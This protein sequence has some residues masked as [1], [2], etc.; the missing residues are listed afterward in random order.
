MNDIHSEIGRTQVTATSSARGGEGVGGAEKSLW[1][2]A[3]HNQPYRLDLCLSII[4]RVTLHNTLIIP[5][6]EVGG[7][8]R[9]E[10]RNN[11]CD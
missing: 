11:V 2:K 5:D 4:S 6:D 8:R 10:R 9:Y 7:D 1:N 3:R